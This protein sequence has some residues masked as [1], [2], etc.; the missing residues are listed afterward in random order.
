MKLLL[1]DVFN[2]AAIKICSWRAV[3]HRC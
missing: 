2:M 1:S 3:C